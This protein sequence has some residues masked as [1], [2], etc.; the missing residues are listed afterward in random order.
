MYRD[1]T[2]GVVVP[3]Y[4]EETL[5]GRVIQTMPQFVDKIIIVN[6]ASTDNTANAVRELATHQPDRVILIDLGRNQ[7]VGGAI[8]E[9][10][11]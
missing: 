4:N 5:I 2:V 6:D 9:G 11:K 7:G 3:A 1:K 10:Y 8:A